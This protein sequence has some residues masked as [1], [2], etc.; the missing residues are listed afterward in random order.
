MRVLVKDYYGQQLTGSGDLKTNACCDA[1]PLPT[2]LKPLLERVH[3]EV[4]KRYY[5]CGLVVP[6]LLHSCRVL[7]LGCGSGRD[8]YLLA[9][10]IGPEGSVLG[11]DM[12]EEQL[13]IAE[14]HHAWHAEVFGYDNVAFRLGY[15]E[16]LD[17]LD[18]EEASFDVVVSNCVVNLSSHKEKVLSDVFRLLK[19]GGE[20]FFSDIYSD[21]RIP[22]TVRHDRVLYGEC[23]GGALYWNDFLRLAKAVGFTDPRLVADHAVTVNDPVMQDKVGGIR[24]FSATYRL[25]KL[26]GLE[27]HCEDYGQAV[28]YRGNVAHSEHAFLLDKHHVMEKG[29]MF[30]VCGNTYRMLRETRFA[31]FFDFYGNTNIHYGIFGDCGTP[32]PFSTDPDQQQEHRHRGCC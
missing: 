14:R 24:F 25:F 6:Q 9:Q 29:R 15:I 21:R 3:P 11:V 1:S 4:Y 17:A 19:P 7:D 20:F 26:E 12:T 31:P 18:L 13:A 32:M 27:S 23:L 10:L 22:D 28:M 2:W 5:G 8:C 30:P 16:E